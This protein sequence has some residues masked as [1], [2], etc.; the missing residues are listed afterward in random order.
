MCEELK[1]CR[2]LYRPIGGKNHGVVVFWKP[3][4]KSQVLEHLRAANHYD[5]FEIKPA[6]DQGKCPKYEEE[7]H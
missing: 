2:W 4:S 1:M 6:S 3:V 7:K 5:E